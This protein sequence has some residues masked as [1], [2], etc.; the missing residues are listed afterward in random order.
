MT[1][2]DPSLYLHN[3]TTSRTPSSELGK[4]E[5]MKILM[6]QLQNQDPLNPMEDREFISQM[7][8]FSSLE[9][10]MQMSNSIDHLVQNQLTSPVIRYSHMIGKEV[11]YQSYDEET[12][13]PGDIMTSK[14]ISVS[15]KDG[16]AILELENGEKVYADAVVKVIDPEQKETPDQSDK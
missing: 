12:D 2:I 14:V 1:K 3:Q 7:A 11:S 8:S 4:D 5:F 15:Q 13:E 9:Q 16:W 6:A 10:M